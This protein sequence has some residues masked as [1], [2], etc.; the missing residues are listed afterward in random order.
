[1]GIIKKEIIKRKNG[2]LILSV[3]TIETRLAKFCLCK[4]T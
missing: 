4:P 3:G 1:M 2:K